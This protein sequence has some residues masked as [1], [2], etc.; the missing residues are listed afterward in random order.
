MNG[1]KKN[2][3]DGSIANKDSLES[4]NKNTLINPEN[5]KDKLN[6]GKYEYFNIS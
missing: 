6:S 2:E 4:Y 1:I 5:L 3:E